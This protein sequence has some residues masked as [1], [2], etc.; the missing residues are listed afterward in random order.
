MK[1]I[2]RTFLCM[3]ALLLDACTSAPTASTPRAINGF[4]GLQLAVGDC[5]V[6]PKRD[7]AAPGNTKAF[8]EAL[9][10]AAISQGVNYL[11]KA[12]AAAGAAKT[13]TLT[14]SRNIQASSAEFPQCVTIVRGAFLTSGNAAVWTAPEGWPGDL[15]QQLVARGLVLERA[16]DFIFEGEFIASS[17]QSALSLRP[18]I[19]T[20]ANPIG[21][22]TLRST[23]ERNTVVFLSITPPGTKPTLDTNPSAAIVLGKL[24]PTA[25][26]SYS[27][28]SSFTSPYDSP[29]FSL[30]KADMKKPLTVYAM[31]SET[32]EESVFLT[33]LGTVF[34][35]SKVTAAENTAL[36][37][38]L[39]PGAKQQ[40]EQEATSKEVTAANDADTKFV[41][42][43]AKLGACKSAADGA[44][45]LSAA[46]E[47]RTALRNYMVA[48]AVLSP[49]QTDVQEAMIKAIDIRKK[50]AEIRSAC[51]TTL[52]QLVKP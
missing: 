37:Q 23:E 45:T 10:G 28:T 13:W 41:T 7:K 26:R 11:G 34:S 4:E 22:R 24:T 31:L 27:T 39:V 25:T 43:L 5:L 52:K 2:A 30:A 38:I 46:A 17:D 6:A 32:Q 40:A 9:I 42:V 51:D 20:F 35:D 18:V 15:Q 50:S 16:P 1:L 33:F 3:S 14:G 12:L 29:W 49:P 8:G 36:T 47:A 19:A 44:P 48:A 21:S